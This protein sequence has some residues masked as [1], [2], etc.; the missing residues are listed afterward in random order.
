MTKT[1]SLYPPA[2]IT[3]HARSQKHDILSKQRGSSQ[4]ITVKSDL[5]TGRHRLLL[6][7]NPDAFFDPTGSA[8]RKG[9]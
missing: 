5:R 9:N 6:G 1:L 2:G 8:N 4:A 3:I 7:K